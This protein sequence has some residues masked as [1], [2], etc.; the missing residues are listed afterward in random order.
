[1]GG[2]NPVAAAREAGIEA[3]NHAMST[4]ID[5]REFISFKEM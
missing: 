1:L 2:L 4:T 5:Y 3:Q